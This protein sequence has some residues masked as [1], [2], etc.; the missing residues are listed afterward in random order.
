M[1]TKSFFALLAAA[2]VLVPASVSAQTTT[3]SPPTPN[4]SAGGMDPELQTLV[5]SIQT[6]LKAGKNTE[7]VLTADL[8]G[9]DKLL[10][11]H[12]GEK[13][14]AVAQILYMKAMLYL[15]VLDNTDKGKALIQKLKADYP[16]TK[17]GKNADRM[18]QM[19]EKQA[20]AKKIQTTLAPGTTFPDFSENDLTGKS[21]S[22]SALK[23]KVVLVDFWATWCGPCVHEIP[24][25]IATHK[26]FQPQGFEIIGVSL[27]SDR[28]KLD[29]FLKK[30]DGMTWPQYFD[31]QGWQNKLASKYGV[32][33]IPFTVLIG[34]D[35]KIIGTDLRAEKLEAAVAAAI[36][37]K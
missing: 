37:K 5:Q 12:A 4:R 19:M 1:N 16:D 10:A 2:A 31:G 35:G 3:V 11:K 21:L 24:N 22:V 17:L 23:G 32:E 7:A 36:V 28:E 18:L 30:Q 20:E 33:S 8:A 29:A 25:V 27:D 34:R 14:E 26:K 6:K 15:Q 13:T 9:F